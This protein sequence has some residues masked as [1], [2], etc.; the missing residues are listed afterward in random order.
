MASRLVYKDPYPKEKIISEFERC[1]N[2]QFDPEIADVV[3]KLIKEGKL[4]TE[5]GKE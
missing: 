1:K 2:I 4:K 5:D 3:G